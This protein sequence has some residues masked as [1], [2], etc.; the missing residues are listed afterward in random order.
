[1]DLQ[2]TAAPASVIKVHGVLRNA[3]ADAERMI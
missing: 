1:M 3:L 2:K